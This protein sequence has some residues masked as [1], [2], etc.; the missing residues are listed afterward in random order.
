MSRDRRRE[1]AIDRLLRA[2]LQPGEGTGA[3]DCPDPGHVAALFEGTLEPGERRILEA[4]VAECERCQ[5]TLATIARMTPT[6]PAAVA[7]WQSW[8][9]SGMRWLVPAATT[10]V[11]AIAV[12][13]ALRPPLMEPARQAPPPIE[14][15]Q[16]A[17]GAPAPSTSESPTAQA[18]NEARAN[19][20]AARPGPEVAPSGPPAS[21]DDSAAGRRQGFATP[22]PTEPQDALVERETLAKG[23]EELPAT[24]PAEGPVAAA[25]EPEKAETPVQQAAAPAL[26]AVGMERDEADAMRRET[27]ARSHLGAAVITIVEARSPDGASVWRVERAGAISYSTDGGRRWAHAASGLSAEVLA[28]S[29]PSA[30]VCW[31]AGRDGSVSLTVGGGRWERRPFPERVDLVGIVARSAHSATVTTRDGRRFAT[32]DGGATWT[33]VD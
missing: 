17:T 27:K 20:P 7:G 24:P 6:M 26:E 22:T 5:E 10:V 30:D 18:A 31:A 32:A 12:Y 2:A 8:W 13:V 29:S 23:V 14:G 21:R 4:H 28:A 19:A 33:L 3:A 11:I 15:K 9:T 16:R 25:P 1:A